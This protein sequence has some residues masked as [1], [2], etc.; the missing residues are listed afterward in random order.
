MPHTSKTAK[1]TADWDL[2]LNA[3]GNLILA[4]DD[5]AIAQ[6]CANEI[7]LFTNDAYFQAD[8]GIDWFNTQ[9]GKPLEESLL[10][11]EI[12]DACMRVSGVVGVVS[13]LLKSF[14]SEERTLSAEIIVRTENSTNVTVRV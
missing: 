5:Y 3:E 2:Q 14:D 1:L 8:N 13:I 6:N 4:H 12:H 10:K 7:R 9:L 11:S